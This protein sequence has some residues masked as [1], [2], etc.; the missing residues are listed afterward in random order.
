MKRFKLKRKLLNIRK[1][2]KKKS[3][4]RYS[5]KKDG[6]IHAESGTIVI[7]YQNGLKNITFQLMDT[8]R[9]EWE[10]QE[11]EKRT[12]VIASINAMKQCNRKQPKL[13]KSVAKM[14]KEYDQLSKKQKRH[15]CPENLT[16][17]LEERKT[18]L[19]EAKNNYQNNVDLYYQNKTTFEQLH[20][21]RIGLRDYFYSEVERAHAA[22]L[23][24]LHAFRDGFNL[25]E[26]EMEGDD[27]T[28]ISAIEEDIQKKKNSLLVKLREFEM[29]EDISD[30]DESGRAEEDAEINADSDANGA[31]KEAAEKEK[32]AN[33][34]AEKAK[35]AIEVAKK[36]AEEAKA[37]KIDADVAADLAE[38]EAARNDRE[39][40]AMDDA[41]R[42]VMI[43][44]EIAADKNNDKGYETEDNKSP[45]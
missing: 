3:S 39:K 38:D 5:V 42:P 2:I 9:S 7:E 16:K 43:D 19:S 33:E 29:V 10:K 12:L 21:R 36:A 45:R 31:A 18:D 1:V 22:L 40:A 6:R 14:E 23:T 27:L 35:A 26:G 13:A 34:A 30:F 32:A 11:E 17:A 25:L 37:A 44:D 20:E 24:D 28:S 41:E 8:L 15:C 4:P